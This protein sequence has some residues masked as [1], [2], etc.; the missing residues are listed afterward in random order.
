[1]RLVSNR[2]W[3]FT[4]APDGLG[5]GVKKAKNGLS[6]LLGKREQL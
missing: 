1:M 3:H 4:Q 5:A 6:A 2:F